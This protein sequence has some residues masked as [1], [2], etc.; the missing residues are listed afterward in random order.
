[1]IQ[2]FVAWLVLIVS[3]ALVVPAT[4]DTNAPS[5]AKTVQTGGRFMLKDHFG[6]VVTDQDFSGKFM[7]VYFGYTYC[8]D[9]C[10][11]SL[12]VITTALEI[13]GKEADAIQP[14]FITVDP[15]RDTASVLREYLSS[16]YP[17]IIG[18]TGSKAMLESVTKKYRVFY[19]K[20]S[21]KG[22]DADDY[23]MDHTASVFFMGPNGEYLA[24]FPYSTT[25]EEMARKMREIIKKAKTK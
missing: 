11:T 1:M 15:E 9:V 14:L 22:A 17:T 5:D 4:A 13:L 24:R 21:E 8:P 23:F 6:R 3:M 7:L 20:T 25:S 2:R 18:L 10:P 16:F 12:Q 19:S